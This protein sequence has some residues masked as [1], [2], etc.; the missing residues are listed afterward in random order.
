[1]L[2]LGFPVILWPLLDASCCKSR[3]KVTER[4]D[5]YIYLREMETG[6][7]AS[8]RKFDSAAHMS[9]KTPV[10]SVLPPMMLPSS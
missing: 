4:N 5:W 7:L 9:P 3:N 1:M 10:S 8:G 2:K 6:G